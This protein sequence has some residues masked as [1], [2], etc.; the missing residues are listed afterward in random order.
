MKQLSLGNAVFCRGRN[1]AKC[2]IHNRQGRHLLR[3]NPKQIDTKGNYYKDR[4]C[5]AKQ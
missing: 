2:H 1:F 4:H 5:Y 3:T